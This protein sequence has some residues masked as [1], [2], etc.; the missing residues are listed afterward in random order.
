LA[1]LADRDERVPP[2]D[3]VARLRAAYGLGLAQDRDYRDAG[4]RAKG[5]FCE[6]LADP[7]ALV[8]DGNPFDLELAECHFEVLDDLRSLVG[9]ADND[10]ELARLVVVRR[11]H[12]ARLVVFR[13]PEEVELALAIIVEDDRE[14]VP[15]Q[16]AGR[17]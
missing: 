12:R 1:G 6:G 17:P 5:G 15:V 9:A 13:A 14:A 4:S 7:R 10:S 8:G 2:F 11:D 3:R 16:R